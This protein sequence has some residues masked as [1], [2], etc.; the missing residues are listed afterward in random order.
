MTTATA[1]LTFE[2]YLELL[3]A[4]GERLAEVAT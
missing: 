4:D 2:R 3:R 1:E